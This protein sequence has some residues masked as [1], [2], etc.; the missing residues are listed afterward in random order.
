MIRSTATAPLGLMLIATL[1]WPAAAQ[2]ETR[3]I[4]AVP[5]AENPLSLPEET[6]FHIVG[7]YEAEVVDGRTVVTVAVDRPGSVVALVLTS[8]EPILWQLETAAGTDVAAVFVDSYELQPHVETMLEVPVRQLDLP[9]LI[10]VEDE[11]FGELLQILRQEFG[12]TRV[13]SA[14]SRYSLP[15]RIEVDRADTGDP[16]LDLDW[17]QPTAADPTVRFSLLTAYGQMHDW[18]LTGPVD[19]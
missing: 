14:Q 13:A 17:P 5:L 15:P 16:P 1:M 19:G 7:G 10:A 4:P 18:T 9:Y 6:E 12:V 11:H 8:H 3:L 2:E